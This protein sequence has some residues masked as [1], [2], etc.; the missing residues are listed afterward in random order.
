MT[1][2]GSGT[3]CSIFGLGRCRYFSFPP[4]TCKYFRGPFILRRAC[5]AGNLERESDVSLFPSSCCHDIESEL[6]N[7]LRRK[8]FQ[9]IYSIYAETPFVEFIYIGRPR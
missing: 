9:R 4:N 3:A 7:G 8:L 5:S 6:G 1:K 2:V